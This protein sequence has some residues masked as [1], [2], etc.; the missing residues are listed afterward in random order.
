VRN[1]PTLLSDPL[2]VRYAGNNYHATHMRNVGLMA[3]ALRLCY[4]PTLHKTRRVRPGCFGEHTGDGSTGRRGDAGIP[5][6]SHSSGLPERDTHQPGGVLP[7]QGSTKGP[8]SMFSFSR[9]LAAAVLALG[10]VSIAAT[11]APHAH[12]DSFNIRY[13]LASPSIIQASLN[14]PDAYGNLTVAVSGTGFSPNNLVYAEAIDLATNT[15]VDGIDT[16]ADDSGSVQATLY[17]VLSP[18]GCYYNSQTQQWDPLGVHLYDEATGQWTTSVQ[19]LHCQPVDSG[20]AL[21]PAYG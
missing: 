20:S 19:V 13:V 11:A 18:D 6:W 7:L 2:R 17:P 15:F 16:V 21:N 8:P 1:N 10:T 12:A 9:S 4:A 5:H 14:A 3:M